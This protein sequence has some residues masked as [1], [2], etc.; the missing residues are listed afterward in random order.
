MISSDTF[1]LHFR[2]MQLEDIE[3]VQAIDRA[4][5]ST[6]WPTRAYHYELN[7]N[8]K[9]ILWVAEINSPDGEKLIVG[10]TVV[11]LIIDE[12]HIATIAVHPDYRQLG[13]GAHLLAKSLES[14][15]RRG[16][17]QATLEVR[18][19]NHAAQSLYK[20]FGFEVVGRRPR[21]YKDNAEDAILMTVNNLDQ[22]YLVWME[23]RLNERGSSWRYS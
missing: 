12:A 20:R 19:S 13:I 11:W 10:M 18:A 6:P 15:I 9:S 7:S 4:S 16:A 3:A 5:F 1:T 21:Y 22:D 23:S 8:S 14:V 2:P 17:E